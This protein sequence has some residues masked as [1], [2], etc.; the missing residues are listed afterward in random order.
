MKATITSI[1]L[2]TIFKFFPLSIYALNIVKQLKTTNC[3]DF[4]KQGFWTL[5][6]T[7]TLWESE[8]QMK[9]FARSGAHLKAMKDSAKIAKEIRTVT[10]DADKLPD[11]KTAKQLLAEAKPY[12]F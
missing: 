3:L 2:K 8:E 1:K 12:R 9:E 4:K 10:I 5:H 7:M 11:W 6:Y